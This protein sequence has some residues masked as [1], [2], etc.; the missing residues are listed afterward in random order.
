M[1]SASVTDE[2]TS[3]LLLIRITPFCACL[4]YTSQAVVLRLV[5][6]LLRRRRRSGFV[7]LG[8]FDVPLDGNGSDRRQLEALHDAVDL[9]KSNA[10]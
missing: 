2:K 5:W 1:P 4:L 7:R 6:L 10:G 9:G 3:P 8:L